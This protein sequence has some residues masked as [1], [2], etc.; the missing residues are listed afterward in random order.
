MALLPKGTS[1]RLHRAQFDDCLPAC[2]S[3][4]TALAFCGL[5]GKKRVAAKR[6]ASHSSLPHSQPLARCNRSFL[7]LS[8]HFLLLT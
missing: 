3:L 7:V 1:A 2:C 8:R 4:P 5:D 6:R